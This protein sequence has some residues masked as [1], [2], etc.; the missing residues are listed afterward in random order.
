MAIECFLWPQMRKY[1]LYVKVYQVKEEES[2]QDDFSIFDDFG[3]FDDFFEPEVIE[4]PEPEVV[5][6]PEPE[7]IE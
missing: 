2:E 7:V 5:K 3:D 4:E 6:E 1:L